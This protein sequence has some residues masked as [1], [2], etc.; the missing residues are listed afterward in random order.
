[1]IAADSRGI[2]TQAACIGQAA[3]N[4][5]RAATGGNTYQNIVAIERYSFK[6]VYCQLWVVL[7]A[8]YCFVNSTVATGNQRNNHARGYAKS[9]WALDGIQNT[10]PATGTRA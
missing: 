8:F 4:I 9:G 2:T 1:G 5:G 3:Q 7:C 10:Q 6:I